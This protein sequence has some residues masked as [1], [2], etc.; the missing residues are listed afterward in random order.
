MKNLK[1]SLILLLAAFIWG[2]A[3]VAQSSGADKVDT[4]TFNAFRSF[5]GVLFLLLV[6]VIRDY[7]IKKT[8]TSAHADMAVKSWPVKGGIVCGIVL[9]L[10]SGFQ[11]A[12]IGMYPDGV[13]ASGRSGFLTATYVVMVAVVVQIVGRKIHPL[14]IMSIIGVVCGLYLLCMSGGFDAIYIGDVFG[15]ICAICFTVHILVIDKY[16]NVD[17]I[18]LSCLQFLVCGILSFTVMLIT[19]EVVLANV[20][21]ALIPILYAGVM[22]SGIAFTLQ[23]VGQKY[24]EPHIASIVMCLESVFAVL[25]GWVVLGE[26][27]LPREYLGC[28]LVFAAVILAQIPAFKTEKK[29]A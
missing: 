2:T 22:S 13:A 10:A 25:A 24:A 29:K 8:A 7:K 9:F 18:K 19:E 20:I 3:F 1:G 11:Q 14:I 28:A 23:M 5:V 27:L 15:F 26:Q 4:F 12:G 6:V 21:E 16:S 17:S